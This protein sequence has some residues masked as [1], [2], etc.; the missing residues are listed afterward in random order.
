MVRT[1]RDRSEFLI[2][3]M[4]FDAVVQIL[5]IRQDYANLKN[6]FFGQSLLIIDL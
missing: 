6:W 2:D 3:F 5:L 4:C 1:H